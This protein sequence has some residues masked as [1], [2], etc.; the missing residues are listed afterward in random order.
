MVVYTAIIKIFDFNQ[1]VKN[2]EINPIFLQKKYFNLLQ[3][4]IGLKMPLQSKP[5]FNS[6]VILEYSISC[7]PSQWRR[8]YKENNPYCFHHRNTKL[9]L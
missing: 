7:E 2:F 5:D 1:K 6:S 3:R 8:T 4:V 9:D